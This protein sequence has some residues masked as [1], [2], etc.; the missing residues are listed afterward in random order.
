[1]EILSLQLEELGLMH[2]K[3]YDMMLR[4]L[5]RSHD[6]EALKSLADVCEPVKGY[7]RNALSDVNALMPYT[8]FIDATK[9][10]AK[11]ARDFNNLVKQIASSTNNNDNPDNFLTLQTTLSTWYAT[12]NSLPAVIDSNPI[13]KEI[14]PLANYLVRLSYIGLQALE[15]VKSGRQ[16]PPQWV[17][18]ALQVCTDSKK[19]HGESELMIVSGIMELIELAK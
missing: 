13:L 2:I 17:D 14:K 3:N 18:Y 5:C 6:I 12:Q 19:P 10:D 1:M 9:P 7:K 11:K 15:Y 4:R 8:R 16:A